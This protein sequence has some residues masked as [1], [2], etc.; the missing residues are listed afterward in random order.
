MKVVHLVI[1]KPLFDYMLVIILRS[2]KDLLRME[3]FISERTNK[4]FSLYKCDNFIY[5]TLRRDIA[6]QE[7]LAIIAGAE[8]KNRRLIES[9]LVHY[10]YHKD[11]ILRAPLGEVRSC[12]SY[13]L[14]EVIPEKCNIV[15]RNKITTLGN[16]EFMNH[17]VVNRVEVSDWRELIRLAFYLR[18]FVVRLDMGEGNCI[19]FTGLISRILPAI[20]PFLTIFYAVAKEQMGTNASFVEIADNLNFV[21]KVTLR[22]LKF[23]PIV[24]ARGIFLYENKSEGARNHIE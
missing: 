14:E 9:H 11:K 10:N 8:V 2:I 13:V 15:E 20:E 19:F 4:R 24:N 1:P 18:D 12:R 23:V 17:R 5:V 6:F 3:A 21:N 7:K 16:F 22:T